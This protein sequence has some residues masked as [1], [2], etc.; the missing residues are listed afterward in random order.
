[1]V[2]AETLLSVV[3]SV[4]DFLFPKFTFKLAFKVLLFKDSW[5]V[6]V[7]AGKAKKVP[8]EHV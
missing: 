3:F 4:D 8:L 5:P 2:L 7:L 1:M 6:V